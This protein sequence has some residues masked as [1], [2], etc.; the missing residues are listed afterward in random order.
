MVW[1]KACPRC[2]GDLV[3]MDDDYEAYY[4]CLQCGHSVWEDSDEASVLVG[5]RT[6]R[7]GERFELLEDD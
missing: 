2:K 1:T 7:P 4:S 5:V 6:V 3:R